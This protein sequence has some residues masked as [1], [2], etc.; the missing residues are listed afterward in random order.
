MKPPLA[1]IVVSSLVDDHEEGRRRRCRLR[2]FV[3]VGGRREWRNCRSG[4]R[5]VSS[6]R[7]KMLESVEDYE[8]NH[9]RQVWKCFGKFNYV[10]VSPEMFGQ[11]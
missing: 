10:W 6:G 2:R 8:R 7:P 3:D 4:R 1:T 5:K 11:V 9:R